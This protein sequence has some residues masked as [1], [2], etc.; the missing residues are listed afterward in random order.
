MVSYAHLISEHRFH[1]LGGSLREIWAH[2]REALRALR[3]P[4]EVRREVNV[5]V[6]ALLDD[7][8][9]GR[10]QRCRSQALRIS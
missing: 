5:F 7:P 2:F 4:I 6:A 1:G 8:D 3:Q 10:P 9:L